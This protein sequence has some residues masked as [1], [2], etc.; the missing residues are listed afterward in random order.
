MFAGPWQKEQ[1]Q[2][3]IRDSKWKYNTLLTVKETDVKKKK[4]KLL[5][6]LCN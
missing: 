4:H 3:L 5:P 1:L 6:F 2:K